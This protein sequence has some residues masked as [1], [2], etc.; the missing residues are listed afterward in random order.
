LLVE[1]PGA[2]SLEQRRAQEIKTLVAQ[3]WARHNDDP[4]PWTGRG[5]ERALGDLIASTRMCGLDYAKLI[6]NRE[7]W[8]GVNHSLRPARWLR[9]LPKFARG[10]RK[11]G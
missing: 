4:C 8:P 5:E 1:K 11:A 9:E 3:Y 2:A 7:S 6:A 10:P